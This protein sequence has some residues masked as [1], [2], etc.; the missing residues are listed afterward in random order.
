MCRNNCIFWK[1]KIKSHIILFGVNCFRLISV[2]RK[3]VFHVVYSDIEEKQNCLWKALTWRYLFRARGRVLLLFCEGVWLDSQCWGQ[4]QR[5]FQGI[6]HGLLIRITH[7]S[8]HAFVSQW[9]VMRTPLP[10]ICNSTFTAT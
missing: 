5:A 1:Q 8:Y 9:P 6:L 10:L 7:S 2:L 4:L 3:L